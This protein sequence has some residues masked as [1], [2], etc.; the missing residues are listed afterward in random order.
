MA[1]NKWQHL[2]TEENLSSQIEAARAEGERA[3]QTEPRARSACYLPQDNIISIELTNNAIFSFPPEL[4]QG[5]ADASPKALADFWMPSS[6]DSIH[7]DSLGVSFSI[8]ALLIGIFGTKNWMSQL[9]AAGGKVSSPAKA[10]SSR[11]NGKKGGRPRKLI[12]NTSS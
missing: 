1:T 12:Q 8:P 5:L 3:N 7:W 4:A 6:G 10:L 9:G 11:E 2:L